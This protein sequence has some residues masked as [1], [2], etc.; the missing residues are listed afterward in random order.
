MKFASYWELAAVFPD[1]PDKS[2]TSGQSRFSV[3][4]WTPPPPG[5]LKLNVD[6]AVASVG[7]AGGVGGLLRNSDRKCLLSFSRY[8]GQ[9]PPLLAE[10]LAIK[11]GLEL[12]FNS[13]WR[14]VD[15]IIVESDNKVVVEWILNPVICTGIF[16]PL[17]KEIVSL[18]GSNPISFRHISRGCNIDAD[19]LAKRGIG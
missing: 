6:G 15:R 19:R 16:S 7:R 5:V 2:K 18:V 17:V 12:F 8:V 13:A 1:C 14:N 9:V 11:I 3:M 10:I 4:S